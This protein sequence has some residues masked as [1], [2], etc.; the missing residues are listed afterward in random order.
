MYYSIERFLEDRR[1]SLIFLYFFFCILLGLSLF[2]KYVELTGGDRIYSEYYLNPVVRN[3]YIIKTVS[4]LI[5]SIH[6]LYKIFYEFS[7]L[8]KGI[9]KTIEVSL[10]LACSLIICSVTWYEFYYGSTFDY[11]NRDKQGL[12][13]MLIGTSLFLSMAISNMFTYKIQK[14]SLILFVFLVS[15]VL[16]YILQYSIFNLLVDSWNMWES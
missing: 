9:P 6:F 10:L 2:F 8:K 4:I 7:L 5:I 11:S 16:I 14:G 13:I 1:A 3:I 12:S 15:A